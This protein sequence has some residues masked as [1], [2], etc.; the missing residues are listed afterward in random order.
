MVVIPPAPLGPLPLRRHE[1]PP[2]TPPASRHHLPRSLHVTIITVHPI[3]VASESNHLFA[4][5]FVHLFVHP[6]ELNTPAVAAIQIPTSASSSIDWSKSIPS[7]PPSRSRRHHRLIAQSPRPNPVI[8]G[9][10]V[11]IRRRIDSRYELSHINYKFRNH[12]LYCWV[13]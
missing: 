12:N 2:L 8:A 10:S 7:S 11:Q 6:G 13:N 5:L 3:I 1:P 9:A 4:F